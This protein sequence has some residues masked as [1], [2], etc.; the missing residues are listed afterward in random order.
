MTNSSPNVPGIGLTNVN[1]A[2]SGCPPFIRNANL[3]IPRGSRCLLVG[4]NGAGKTSMLQVVAGKYMVGK[5][6][7]LVLGR[8]PFHD[9]QLTCSGELSYLGTSWRK[10]VACAG[11]GVPLQGDVS[12]GKMI[13]GVEGIDPK[14]RDTLVELLDIDLYQRMNVMS[15]GQRRR[16]QIC[17]GLLKPYEVLL[18]DEITVDLDVVGRLDLLAF[19]KKECEERG[20]TILYATHIFDGLEDWIS[21]V[22]YMEDGQFVK[23]G[24][25]EDI[26]ATPESQAVFTDPTK[27]KKLLNLV[28]NWLRKDFEKGAPEREKRM[29][30]G[31]EAE[32]EH[33]KPNRTPIMP[34]KH[35][36]YFY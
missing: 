6:D 25:F 2:Y 32:Q 11:Y 9:M 21:H 10:D 19:F 4:A 15:D 1:F 17:M 23:S 28:E 22:A 31:A 30:T 34:S 18:M 36:A 13:F 8:S 27:P 16:V 3:E 35:L 24:R 14:R 26:L 7:V 33:V 20:A 29:L 12:A 5:E